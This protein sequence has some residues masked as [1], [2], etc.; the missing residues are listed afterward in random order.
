MGARLRV[1]VGGVRMEDDA[2]IAAD[3]L[4]ERVNAAPLRDLRPSEE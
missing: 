3:A 4:P 2:P 1:R